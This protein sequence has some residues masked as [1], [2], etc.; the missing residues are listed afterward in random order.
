LAAA[1]LGV[2]VVTTTAA[3][4]GPL[5]AR[6]AGESILQDHLRQAGTTAGVSQHIDLDIGDPAMY[7]HYRARSLRPGAIQGYDRVIAGLYTPSGVTT[8]FPR[9]PLGAV[10]THLVW[11]DGQ[12]AHLVIVAGR[13]PSRPGEAIAS[14]RVVAA[15]VYRWRLGST[16]TLGQ[17]TEADDPNYTERVP[18]PPPVRIVGLYR[19]M[20]TN[21]PYWFGQQ[22]FE[23][24]GA[25][26]PSGGPDTVDSLFV[27]H[28]EFTSLRHNSY[29]EAFFDYPLTA[30]AVRLNDAS[31]ERDAVQGLLA[32]DHGGDSLVAES[33]LP[34]VLDAAARERHLVNI[35]TLLVT[36]QLAALA[37]LVL[38]QVM[39]DAIEARGGEIAIAKLR[40]HSAWSTAWFGL[41]EPLVLL[42]AAVPLG[43]AAALGLTHLFAAAV[44]VS[45]VPVVLPAAAVG[46]CL[47]GF[48][49]GLVAAGLAGYRTLSRSVLEQ[50]RRTERLPGHGKLILAVDVMLAAAAVIGLVALLRNR[51]T[52]RV[53]DTAALLAPGLMVFAVAVLG[54][55]LLPP[56]C[57]RLARATRAGRRV[58][59]FLASRQVARRP[60]G[61]RLAA[62]LAVAVGLA[63]F[64][65]AGEGI[66]SANRSARATGELGADGVASVQFNPNLDPVAATHKADPAGTWAMAAATWLPNGGPV[67]GTVLGVDSSRLA[68]VASSTNGAPANAQLAAEIGTAPVAPITITA[69]RV[70]V[71]LAAT[72][73]TGD[74]RPVV[75]VNLRT[76][77]QPSL[78]VEGSP[79]N[80]GAHQ[81]VIAVP[82]T[83]GCTLRGLTWDRPI[84]AEQP[85]SGTITLTGLDVGGG[86]HWAP[87]DIGLGT[88]RSW[89]P[90]TP[91]SGA[92][93]QVRITPSGVR[94]EFRNANGGYGG[95]AY[96]ADPSPIP[97]VATPS[98]LA[99]SAPPT[100][101]TM[102]DA[103]GTSASF[104]VGRY[105]RVLPVVL[106]NGLIM[107]VR[108]LQG[109]LPGFV[110]EAKWQVWL[111]PR[112]PSDALARLAAAGLQAQDVSTHSARVA[113]LGRQAPALALL[114]L[115][116]C[117]IA[118][119]VL[120][121]GG[122]AISIT[123]SSRRRSYEI[124]A[125]RTVGA[126]RRSLTRAS[127]M[128]QILL[129]GTAVLLGVPT[130][131]A[132]AA[133]AMPAIPEFANPTPIAMHYTPQ[134]LPTVAFT[135]AFV[136][137]LLITA[138][139]AAHALIRIAVPARLR[140]AE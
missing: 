94:D 97:V 31:A 82:C 46:T 120:A 132:A 127:V 88:A 34:A 61:L 4:L 35:D 56:A 3:A 75:Q 110:T 102:T 66:T 19:P 91:I 57:R 124:A 104:A 36:V 123:A 14:Q 11:R 21:D 28:S 42:A 78:N 5:Y 93:D 25:P 95:I 64:A 139:L 85:L 134:L 116:A 99:G 108:Y 105:V 13:C 131:L 27:A 50:W 80:T 129:L 96:G 118:G 140:D 38:F 126:S 73:L 117:A 18:T 122:T 81:Y 52:G 137:L 133:L 59:I 41:G 86:A 44:L 30:A 83:A 20:N 15:G 63:I 12:C 130:G 62:F 103:I 16:I 6:A 109:E 76:A 115:L 106:T 92:V 107:D 98:A 26:S 68:T 89:Y 138:R 114:L 72:R 23:W 51:A 70:R 7:A 113:Q 33:G 87:L 111:G 90:S 49:G 74:Q 121:V 2:A 65:V 79:I 125:L 69:R 54:V 135:V 8:Y 22:Y 47:L 101:P 77:S 58:G 100:N 1:L 71:H 39:A 136:V 119:A 32:T 60:V 29:V 55:R 84:S 37:W 10:G 40:G 53:D 128:E 112:A 24:Y 48:F 17:I 45:D 43:L 67:T 9:S